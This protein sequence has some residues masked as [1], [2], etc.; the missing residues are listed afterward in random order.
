MTTKILLVGFF[1]L[2]LSLAALQAQP[3]VAPSPERPGLEQGRD[4]GLYNVTNS[5][6]FGYRFTEIG[7]DS[8]LF[9]SNENFG[10]GLRLFGGSLDAKS[11]DAHGVLFD[12]FSLAS[13]GLGNDPY[14]RATLKIEKNDV[15]RYDLTWRRSDYFNP[16]LA[17]GG[18]DTLKRT[19]RTI[20][21][22]DLTLSLA[23]WARLKLG[24]GRNHE[25]GPEFTAYELYIGGLARSVLPI[26][27][28]ARRDWNE[29]RLGTEL[30]LH[31][32]RISLQHQWDYYKDDSSYA[33][34]VPGQPYALADLLNQPY[35]ASLPV[36][37]PTI[38]TAYSRSAPMHIRTP[39]WFLNINRTTT[40]WAVNAR[41]SYNKAEQT[42]TYAE[43]ETGASA[44]ANS[45][46]SNCGIGKPG[47]AATFSNGSGR[48]AF[49]AG[50]LSFSLFP[51]SRLT[52]TNSTS[53][54]NNLYDGTAQ[55]F[56]PSTVAATKNVFWHRSMGSGR[57][58]DSLDANYRV[59]KWLGLHAEYRYTDR[60]IDYNLIRTGTTNNK[61]LNSLSNHMHTATFGIQ[62]KPL[63][64]LSINLDAGI[65][66]ETSAE[67]PV[68]PAHFHNLRGRVQ[69]RRNRLMLVGTYRQLYNLN[70]P[71]L[72][73]FTTAYGPPPPSY[74]ASH[75][76]DYSF[77]SSYEISRDFSLDVSYSKTHLDSMANLWVEEPIANTATIISV[78]GYVSEYISNIHTV[79]IMTRMAP[80]KRVTLYAGYNITH[81]TGDGR[82]VQ[83]LGIT[84]P[85]AEFLAARQTFPMTYQAPMARLSISLSPKLRWNGGWEFYRYHQQ[86]AFYRYQP[87]YRAQT[88]YTSLSFTF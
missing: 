4:V 15:Y 47:T 53:A 3:V 38:A 11:K 67:T 55:I 16:Y 62:L 81:D 51:T 75:S 60:W 30:H 8:G 31:G 43:V 50:D 20:Q 71:E 40:L 52:I 45:A 6:E 33:S 22:H 48:E 24:Y 54:Q 61:D 72:V 77:S 73:P 25:A 65:G 76:R 66:R 12:T 78:P 21:D 57:V 70:A 88:G 35:Q 1:T 44:V 39:G 83:D 85:A 36:T 84:D 80:T 42:S 41:V 86:F 59:A 46:C 7:G 19:R 28:D 58:S 2:F 37:W 49:S 68:A 26:D 14:E 56:Q 27:R 82:N 69:Y 79:S 64:P 87:Y 34:L 32:F 29:Y 17:N 10:N 74:Y 5:F 63:Q 9:R 18:G 13:Q 23:K